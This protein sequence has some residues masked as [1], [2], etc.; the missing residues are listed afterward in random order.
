MPWSHLHPELYHTVTSNAHTTPNP[1]FL[2]KRKQP[3]PRRQSFPVGFCFA[4]C[5]TGTCRYLGC[6]YRYSCPTC[7]GS[8]IPAQCPAKR[9]AA[10]LPKPQT[11]NTSALRPAPRFANRKHDCLKTNLRPLLTWSEPIGDAERAKHVPGKTNVIADAQSRFQD[12]PDL[13]RQYGLKPMQSVIPPDL[14]PWPL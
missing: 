10:V 6:T 7:N 1:A 11:P 3:F 5:T 2:P 13:R 12:T 8:H 9:Q 14:L 4:F